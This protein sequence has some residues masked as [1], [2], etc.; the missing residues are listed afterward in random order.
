MVT[1]ARNIQARLLRL[2]FILAALSFTCVCTPRSAQSETIGFFFFNPD[3]SQ[4]NPIRLKR[5]MDSTLSLLEFPVS[6]QSFT[7]LNDFQKQF[8]ESK[9]G[10]LFVPDWFLQ[11]HQQQHNLQPLLRPVHRGSDTYRKVLLTAQE[12]S[13]DTATTNGKSL[14]MTPLGPAEVELLNEI[15]FAEN[16]QTANGLNIIHVPKD[17]DALFAL[18]LQQVDFAL[19]SRTNLEAMTIQ[20]PNLV[21]LV[22]PLAETAPI[23]NPVLCYV[24][25]KISADQLR[26]AKNLFLSIPQKAPGN[27]VLEMLHI[28]DWKDISK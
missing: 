14:A 24:K 1:S 7:H 8:T 10:L 18:A 28:D 19:V 22:R 26:A 9:P 21:K 15:L 13:G 2:F 20:N 5:E 12:Q 25:D 23:P 3:S 6:F 11:R 4:S 17:S 27:N 16:G